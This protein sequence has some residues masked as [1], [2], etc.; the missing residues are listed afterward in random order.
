MNEREKKLK[1]YYCQI[2]VLLPCSRKVKTAI[3]QQ[4]QENIES[5]LSEN[6]SSD[7]DQI[8]MQFGAPES[9]AAAYVENTGTSDILKSLHIRKTIMAV[10][11]TVAIVILVAWATVVTWAAVKADSVIRSADGSC[12]ISY[13]VE[14]SGETDSSGLDGIYYVP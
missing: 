6:P 11:I 2:R 10:V 4:I 3:M 8:K 13:I 9:I 12:D 7:F 14:G 1:K 5:Y